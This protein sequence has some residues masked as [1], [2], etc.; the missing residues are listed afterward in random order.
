MRRTL[1]IIVALLAAVA[2]N[3]STDATDLA[4]ADVATADPAGDVAA[5]DLAAD[6]AADPTPTDATLEAEV[7][8]PYGAV[9][10]PKK[11]MV[12]G[13]AVV[14]L[15]GTPYEMGQQQATL[16]HQELKDAVDFLNA[17]PLLGGMAEAARQMGL[18][19]IAQS[20]SYPQIK[21]ECQGMVDTATDTGWTMEICLLL[22]FGDVLAESIQDGLANIQDLMPGCSQVVASGAA[23][24]DGRMYHARNLDWWQVDYIVSHPTIFVRQPEGGIPHVIIGFP[25]NLSPYQGMNVEGVALATNEVHCRDNT[26]HDLT[27]RSHVQTVEVL[28]GSAKTLAEVRT[29]IT[30]LNHMSQETMVASD[31]KTNTA[32]VFEMAP[33]GVGIRE[34][35]DGVVTATNHFLQPE[36]MGLDKDP[37]PDSSL[38]RKTRLDQLAPKGGKDTL[39]GKLDPTGLASILRDR[40]NPDTGATQPDAFDDGGLSLATNGALYQVIFDPEARVFWLAAGSL[41]VPDL[42]MT[43][44]SLRKLLELPGAPDHPTAIPVPK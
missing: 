8:S 4:A 41:P 28:L 32:A 16:L 15:A 7:A 13:Y 40:V 11:D 17:D 3:D 5:T 14:W 24:P 1:P 42:P 38:L 23:T 21:D 9:V 6:L 22:N 12:N 35:V 29:T 34:P 20:N 27:G 36:T 18:I 33:L 37:I 43:G 25:G 10:G 19:D 2:C 26:V 44:F 31:G 39:Y 30:G